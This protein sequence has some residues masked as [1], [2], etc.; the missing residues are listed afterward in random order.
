MILGRDSAEI[1]FIKAIELTPD[2]EEAH[3]NIA[4]FYYTKNQ[5]ERTL[6]HLSM[7]VSPKYDENKNNLTTLVVQ[8]MKK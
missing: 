4:A 1:N 5:F 3:L 6:Y 8:S 7:V 2:F